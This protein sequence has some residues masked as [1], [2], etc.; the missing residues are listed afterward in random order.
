[1]SMIDGLTIA[2]WCCITGNAIG[3]YLNSRSAKAIKLRV[4]Q[5]EAFRQEAHEHLT[6][7]SLLRAKLSS[8]LDS[9]ST[10]K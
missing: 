5:A 8:K 3:L 1:M 9:Q 6:H 4:K 2:L 10:I 7:C